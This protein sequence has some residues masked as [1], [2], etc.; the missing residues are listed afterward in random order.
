MSEEERVREMNLLNQKCQYCMEKGE[1]EGFPVSHS[2]C[3]YC[4]VGRKIHELDNATQWG[5]VDWTNSRYEGL[6]DSF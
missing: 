2:E 4:K 5:S 6:Y 1:R 3:K